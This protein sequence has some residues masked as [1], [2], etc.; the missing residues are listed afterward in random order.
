[1]RIIK[2]FLPEVIEQKEVLR[3]AKA[4]K[5]M[6]HWDNVVGTFLAQHSCPE[7]FKHGTLWIA[8][9]GSSWT[10]ELLLRQEKILE[11]LNNLAGQEGL[12]LELRAKQK[13][14]L[15]QDKK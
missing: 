6:K 1:M 12:F 7:Q 13:A 9:D 4:L 14:A 2:D 5:A 8:T 3:V 11:R 10:Q 15:T